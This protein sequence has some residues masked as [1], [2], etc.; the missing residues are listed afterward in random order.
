MLIG[1]LPVSTKHRHIYAVEMFNTC[2][3]LTLL[4]RGL[5]I[6]TLQKVCHLMPWSGKSVLQSIA[7][8]RLP[9]QKKL[10]LPSHVPRGRP[11]FSSIQRR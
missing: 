8:Q 3:Y 7:D 2:R 1:A 11:L 5:I 10:G 6:I 4:Y 9:D